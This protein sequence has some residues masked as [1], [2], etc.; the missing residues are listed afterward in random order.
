[1]R[2]GGSFTNPP[3]RITVPSGGESSGDPYII[4]AGETD[5]SGVNYA[6]II[7]RTPSL[8]PTWE[9]RLQIRESP[10]PATQAQ[11]ELVLWDTATDDQVSRLI[12]SNYIVSTDSIG[13]VVG[14]KW[15]D[16]QHGQRTFVW[17]HEAIE[18]MTQSTLDEPNAQITLRSNEIRFE[19]QSLPSSADLDEVHFGQF[20]VGPVDVTVHGNLDLDSTGIG[21]KAQLT[22]D[23]KILGFDVAGAAGSA[24]GTCTSASFIAITGAATDTFVKSHSGTR[25]AMHM[26]HSLYSTVAGTT[27]E[28]GLRFDDG[29]GG[30]TDYLIGRMQFNTVNIRQVI[31]GVL[32][33]SGINAGTYTVTPVWRRPVSAAGVLTTNADDRTSWEVESKRQA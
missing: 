8:P 25:V 10:I 4:I 30:V 29:A 17:A 19:G 21:N 20:N 23:T 22:V 28:I 24:N 33:Q 18:I 9:Y 27:A 6:S 5:Q 3:K 12:T 32:L 11:F 31:S 15:D 16:P 26:H 1:M 13:T 7:F 2:G 14:P